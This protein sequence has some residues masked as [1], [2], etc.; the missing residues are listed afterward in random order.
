MKL[1]INNQGELSHCQS[2]E[3]NTERFEHGQGDEWVTKI[4]AELK[5]G[6]E[7]GA[8]KAVHKF[9]CSVF[10]LSFCK[11]TQGCGMASL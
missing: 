3:S 4:Q 5:Q 7:R 11:D 2:T 1:H 10:I 9:I 6:S 8:G